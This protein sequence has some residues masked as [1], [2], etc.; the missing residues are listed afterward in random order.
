M[1]ARLHAVL[2]CANERL[3]VSNA[4]KYDRH[5]FWTQDCALEKG[6]LLRAPSYSVSA[7]VCVGERSEDR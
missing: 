1:L 3:C 2:T 6:A 4:R 5:D 7:L